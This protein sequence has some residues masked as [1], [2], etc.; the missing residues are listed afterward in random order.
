MR[1][2]TNKEFILTERR[3]DGEH[4]HVV[5]A[6]FGDGAILDIGGEVPTKVAVARV[7]GDVA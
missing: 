2:A 4:T 7:E 6:R 1:V 3:N 5:D